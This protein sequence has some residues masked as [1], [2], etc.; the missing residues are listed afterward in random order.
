MP[1]A[2]EAE[3]NDVCVC[4]EFALVHK[5]FA[6]YG[7]AQQSSQFGRTAYDFQTGLSIAF[8]ADYRFF[9]PPRCPGAPP[10]ERGEGPNLGPDWRELVGWMIRLSLPNGFFGQRTVRPEGQ[11]LRAVHFVEM[12]F[13]D[14]GGAGTGTT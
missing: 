12:G 14:F 1:G 9:H 4:Y 3:V 7:L 8:A 6:N 13:V 10:V 5:S 11:G 2:C